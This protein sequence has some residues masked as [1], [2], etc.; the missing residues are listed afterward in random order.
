MMEVLNSSMYDI[1]TFLNVT[2]YPQYTN[3]MIIKNFL[4]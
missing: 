3:K 4:K 2:M 1:R